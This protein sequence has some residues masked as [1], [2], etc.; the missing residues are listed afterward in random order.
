M[1]NSFFYPVLVR[2]DISAYY[3]KEG[4]FY[5][6]YNCEKNY[7]NISKDCQFRCVYCDAHIDECG[8]ERFSLDHFRP[9]DIFSG[10]FNGVL[11]THP[12]NLHLSCQKC[13]VLKTNDWKGCT[14]TIDGVTHLSG[15]GYVD[16]F[17]DDITRYIRVDDNGLVNSI[18]SNGPGEYMI[19]KML[20]NRT[21]RVYIRKRRIVKEKA[22]RIFNLLLNRQSQLM[23]S[24]KFGTD[25]H[26][27]EISKLLE[28]F[29]RFKRLNLLKL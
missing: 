20:L 5:A 17:K 19:R 13:N 23:Y 24:N 4:E 6:T 29:D 22:S 11:K 8:G 26:K 18:S 2:Q 9:T 25:E 27:D 7:I 12:F 16:R 21:N 28:L 1:I 3:K 14:D 10:K 15:L